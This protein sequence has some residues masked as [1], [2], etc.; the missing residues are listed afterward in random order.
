MQGHT[1]CIMDIAFLPSSSNELLVSCGNDRQAHY[2]MQCRLQCL[3]LH[4]LTCA[5]SSGQVRLINLQ[6]N[7]IRPYAYHRGK[8]KTLAVLDKRESCSSCI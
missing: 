4:M 6:K 7:A 3:A 5:L 2:C 1:A 8:V